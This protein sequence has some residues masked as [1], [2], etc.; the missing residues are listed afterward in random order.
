MI[1]LFPIT[2]EDGNIDSDNH[3]KTSYALLKQ[4]EGDDEE[5]WK[6]NVSNM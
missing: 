6:N 2:S 5:E 4:G 1:E 3:L